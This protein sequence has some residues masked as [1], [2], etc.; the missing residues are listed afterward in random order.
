MTEKITETKTQVT[1]RALDRTVENSPKN[2]RNQKMENKSETSTAGKGMPAPA[3]RPEGDRDAGT[4]DRQLQGTSSDSNMGLPHERDQ[5]TNM[6]DGT[7]DPKMEQAKKDVD[8]GLE[9]TSKGAETDQTY[10]QYR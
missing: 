6:T 7:P 10:D 9:D 8:D 4:I 5:M 1:E 2:P 3:A